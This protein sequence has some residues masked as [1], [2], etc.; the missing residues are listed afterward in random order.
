MLQVWSKLLHNG[1]FA[2]VVLNRGD[3]PVQMELTWEM[4]GLSSTA[5][6]AVRDLWLHKSLGNFIGA[7]NVTVG[8]HDVFTARI[9]PTKP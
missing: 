3:R 2:A 9:S 1:D 7:I 6:A 8:S 4:L 5:T